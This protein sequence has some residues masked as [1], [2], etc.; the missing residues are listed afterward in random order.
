MVYFFTK[1]G[2]AVIS[3]L[4]VAER[5]FQGGQIFGGAVDVG[6]GVGGKA[7]VQ[8]VPAHGQV[9]GIQESRKEDNLEASRKSAGV[10]GILVDSQ[11]PND[12]GSQE[13]RKKK[14]LTCSHCGASGING[15][16]KLLLH[17]DR[18]HSK[19]VSCSICRVEFVDRFHF[20]QHSPSCYY[21]CPVEGCDYHEK[22][23]SRF[24]GHL[25]KHR[26]A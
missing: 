8:D 1:S 10:G 3:E 22:R 5:L 7:G 21:W 24:N 19:P 4:D 23:E 9:P 16:S 6:P 11:V 18:M 15:M 2:T 25:R 17:I 12:A 20:V 26:L 14:G 13:V